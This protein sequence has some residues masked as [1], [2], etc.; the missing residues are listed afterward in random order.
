[1]VTEVTEVTQDLV[2][3]VVAMGEVVEVVEMVELE[4]VGMAVTVEM[5]AAEEMSLFQPPPLTQLLQTPLLNQL[6]E[7]LCDTEM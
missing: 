1:M 4:M 7:E 3:V 2:V 5:E 6:W